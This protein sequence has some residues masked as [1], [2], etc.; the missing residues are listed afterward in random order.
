M[1]GAV[2]AITTL[3]I[4]PTAKSCHEW[5]RTFRGATAF[6]FRAKGPLVCLAQAIGLGI[7]AEI[8]EQ[9]RRPGRL[10]DRSKPIHRNLA[11]GRTV[12]PGARR[13]AN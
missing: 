6:G 3:A 11:N 10:E 4:W 1:L 13:N 2:H 5:R 8:Y 12:G 9:G 7:G